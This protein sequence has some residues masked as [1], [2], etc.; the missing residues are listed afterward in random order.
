MRQ[1]KYNPKERSFV[2]SPGANIEEGR[3]LAAI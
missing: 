2:V 1:G 3:R